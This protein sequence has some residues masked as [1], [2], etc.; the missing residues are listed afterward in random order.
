MGSYPNSSIFGVEGSGILFRA[1]GLDLS[2]D[3]LARTL[4]T[5]LGRFLLV[6]TSIGFTLFFAEWVLRATIVPVGESYPYPSGALEADSE[7]GYRLVPNQRTLMT[8]GHYRVELRTDRHGRRDLFDAALPNPGYV[9]VGDSQTFGHGVEA[10]ETWVEQL[11]ERLGANVVNAGVFGYRL[12]QY[13]HVLR[14]IHEEGQPV[15][16]V[17]YGMSWN[18]LSSGGIP[19]DVNTI[20]D[21]QLVAN[22]VYAAPRKNLELRTRL[23]TSPVVLKL[24]YHTA[25]GSRVRAAANSIRSRLGLEADRITDASF[26]ADG[27]RL[28]RVLLEIHGYLQSIGAQLVIVHLANANHSMTDRWEDYQRRYSHSRYFVRETLSSWARLHRIVFADATDEL[29]RRY[30]ESGMERASLILPVDNHYNASGH[31]VIAR[32]FQRVLEDN[33]LAR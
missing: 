23:L 32:V 14:R 15:R 1:V 16:V 20:V 11:Q 17:L 21:G 3:S 33:G 12:T 7:I 25:I 10:E 22:P 24:T 30:L 4:V 27:L 9:A 31:E 8:N 5:T 18:D 29:E 2:E 28:K 6:V 26:A 13:E 19:A